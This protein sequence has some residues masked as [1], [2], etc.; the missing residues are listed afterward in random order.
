[1]VWEIGLEKKAVFRR[2]SFEL[3][4]IKIIC[5]N[6]EFHQERRSMEAFQTGRVV[7]VP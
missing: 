7:L 4:G 5:E 6:K 1:M 2:S 3:G